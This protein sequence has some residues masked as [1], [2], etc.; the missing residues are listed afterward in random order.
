[1]KLVELVVTATRPWS[2]MGSDWENGRLDEVGLVETVK[3]AAWSFSSLF[4]LLSVQSLY[5][6]FRSGG[7]VEVAVVAARAFWPACSTFSW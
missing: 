2:G 5:S 6:R 3:V 1:M 4:W 7:A